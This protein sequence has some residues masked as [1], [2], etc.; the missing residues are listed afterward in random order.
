MFKEQVLKEKDFRLKVKSVDWSSF[1][2]KIVGLHCSVDAII[3]F[4]AYMLI[5]S[6]LTSFAH[7]IYYSSNDDINNNIIQNK[8]SLLN[9]LEYKD[10]KVIV[11][12]C[13]HLKLSENTYVK[14][15]EKL[16]PIVK[17]IMYGEPCSTVP[18]YKKGK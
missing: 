12:G 8:I 1:K 14:L 9:P 3:P 18:I 17:S 16:Q 5:S 13:S 10:K 6:N 15:I 11:K 7:T 4:W 2:N